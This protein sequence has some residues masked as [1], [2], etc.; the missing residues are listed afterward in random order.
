MPMRGVYLFFI[1]Y[2]YYDLLHYFFIFLNIFAFF[3]FFFCSFKYIDKYIG[4]TN[5]M[6]FNRKQGFQTI[7]EN[8]SRLQKGWHYHENV[9]NVSTTE[10]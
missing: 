7:I 6:K 10:P 4:N 8:Y 1:Y 2:F 3:C 9:R 5:K